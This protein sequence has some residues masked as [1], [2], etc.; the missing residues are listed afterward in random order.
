MKQIE[1]LRAYLCRFPEK[2]NKIL[3]TEVKKTQFDEMYQRA[4][5]DGDLQTFTAYYDLDPIVNHCK[6]IDSNKQLWGSY[7]ILGWINYCLNNPDSEDAV[8]L[9]DGSLNPNDQ[10][11]S[12]LFRIGFA[13]DSYPMG[14]IQK[15]EAALLNVEKELSAELNSGRCKTE[16]KEILEIKPGMFGITIDVKEIWRRIGVSRWVGQFFSNCIES[17]RTNKNNI[18]TTAKNRDKSENYGQGSC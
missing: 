5:T 14:V 16:K 7:F 15:I 3:D 13:K 6:E 2:L 17:L 12:E 10:S 8:C 11:I 1:E 4:L 18:V 9:F